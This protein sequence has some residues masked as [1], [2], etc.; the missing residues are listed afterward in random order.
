M[1]RPTFTSEMELESAAVA[2]ELPKYM[3]YA[4]DDMFDGS[5]QDR[6]SYANFVNTNL[7]GVEPAVN[8]IVSK[9]N[10]E[11][12]VSWIG[13]SRA[14]KGAYDRHFRSQSLNRV[15]TASI[16]SAGNFDVFII[17]PGADVD[18]VSIA[19]RV[20][21]DV[22]A[23]H[24]ELNRTRLIDFYKI[25]L[26]YP[27]GKTPQM[28]GPM[29]MC[30]LFPC[31]SV[32]IELTSRPPNRRL[33]EE[34]MRLTEHFPKLDKK[35]LLYVEVIPSKFEAMDMALFRKTFL[36]SDHKLGPMGLLT[37]S[38]FM[39]HGRPEKGL[40][41][42]AYRNEFMER[43]VV[44]SGDTRHGVYYRIAESYRKIFGVDMTSA[45]KYDK[46]DVSFLRNMYKKALLAYHKKL[47][48]YDIEEYYTFVLIEKLRPAINTFLVY[49]AGFLKAS[50]STYGAHLVT[51]GG[52]AMRRYIPDAAATSDIDT[53]V[54]HSKRNGKGLFEVLVAFVVLLTKLLEH[55]FTLDMRD[56]YVY[57]NDIT[58]GAK[59]R[60]QYTMALPR[61]KLR[62]AGSSESQSGTNRF[63]VRIIEESS[64][65]PVNLLSVDTSVPV[66]VQ[67]EGGVS[68]ESR[69]VIPIFDLVMQE[70]TGTSRPEAD[71]HRYGDGGVPVASK[72]FLL[73]D[74]ENTY[75]ERSLAALRFFGF[76]REKDEKRFKRLSQVPDGFYD[77]RLDRVRLPAIGHVLQST[78][79]LR[80]DIMENSQKYRCRLKNLIVTNHR[81][82]FYKHKMPFSCEKVKRI[83]TKC[84]KFDWNNEI[85][86]VVD[87]N[88]GVGGGA[89][90]GT[91]Q[92]SASPKVKKGGGQNGKQDPLKEERDA[93]LR[94]YLP[95]V[96]NQVT[97]AA[98]GRKGSKR[99]KN[100]PKP[101]KRKRFRGSTDRAQDRF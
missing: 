30:A 90:R 83:E 96:T 43:M 14:W 13:G 44:A 3:R 5:I 50:Y 97:H 54:Y 8:A 75:S 11:Y 92:P 64:A 21:Q 81:N 33:T 101:K 61:V 16:A 67:M 12:T 85:V 2:A 94:Q 55:N 58:V 9:Y 18:F 32:A 100:S 25:D 26:V 98:G 20:G 39:M 91:S 46:N 53:K 52:D 73:R 42:D 38:N 36:E 10:N 51:V 1:A 24:T 4:S 66:S 65:F 69:L 56:S 49:L 41:V 27:R 80:Y 29:P 70:T 74:L 6:A 72:A 93:I 57:M 62:T 78:G 95:S 68:F 79:A 77:D 63:R 82:K 47:Y 86:R 28:R 23:I 59:R 40:N 84:P 48:K 17:T 35:L 60:G 45:H 76:K 89:R 71:V 99:A 88:S 37:F 34:E 87:W 31:W 22:K 15:E 19:T 7:P